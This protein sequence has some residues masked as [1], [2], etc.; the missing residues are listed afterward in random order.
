MWNGFCKTHQTFCET[1]FMEKSWTF[2][3]IK[4]KIA[5]WNSHPELFSK[6]GILKTMTKFSIKNP[7]INFFMCI[8]QRFPLFIRKSTWLPR[9]VLVHYPTCFWFSLGMYKH[10]L[11]T[12]KQLNTFLRGHKRK[13]LL[14]LFQIPAI[15]W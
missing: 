5:C 6:S 9:I 7:R 4:Y 10:Q 1:L 2:L 15:E 12:I 3:H 13:F 11:E 8:L 14:Q